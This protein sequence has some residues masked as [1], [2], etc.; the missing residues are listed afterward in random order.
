M[1]LFRDLFNLTGFFFLS[2][3]DGSTGQQPDQQ[4]QQQQQ[5][6]HHYRHH[7]WRR[8]QELSNGV[9]Y[10]P[11]KFELQNHNGFIRRFLHRSELLD[12]WSPSQVLNGGDSVTSTIAPEDWVF[13]SGNGT[14]VKAHIGSTA[15]LPCNIKKDSQYGMVSRYTAIITA[16][17]AR[18]ERGYS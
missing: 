15:M 14:V 6:L 13:L 11:R 8:H 12:H 17:V 4:Q 1:R 16:A 3:P 7:R 9:R 10:V 18:S 5:E 2:F